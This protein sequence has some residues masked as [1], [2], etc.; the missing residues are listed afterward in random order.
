M[1]IYRI[2]QIAV[3]I[4]ILSPNVVIGQL[5]EGGIP[6]QVKKLK[7]LSLDNTDLVVMPT[8]NNQQLRK[9]FSRNEEN[10]LKPFVFA[11]TFDVSLSPGNSGEWYNTT[12]VNVWQLRIQSKSAYSLNLVLEHFKLP[13]GARLF[14]ISST[15]GE[16]KGAYT[17]A[18]NSESQI[19][20]I[21]PV[22]G[23]ELMV[24]YEEPVN[25]SFSG[26]FM[27]TKIAHDFVGIT[28]DPHRPKGPA[29][30]CNVNINCEEANGFENNRDAVCRIIIIDELCTGTL[31]NNTAGNG[32]PYLLTA[33]HCINT[34][35]KA[36][37][38]IFL[39]NY[40]SPYCCKLNSPSI[41][42]D[43]SRTLSGSSLK[44]SFDSL[45][46]ALVRLNQIPPYNYRSYLAG[47]N[48]MNTA[49]SSSVCIHHPMGD[50]KKVAVD[51]DAPLTKNYT[52]SYLINGFWNIV[53]WD[54]GVTEI[55]SSGAGLFD[56]NKR[57]IGSLTGGSADCISRKNDFFEKFALSWDYR[58]EPNKQLKA[59]LDP[60]NSNAQNHNGM[61]FYSGN[62]I[63][64]AFTNFLENDTYAIVQN[65]TG[66]KKGY[67]SGTNIAGFTE[68][69][70]QFKISSNSEVQGITFGIASVKVHSTGTTPTIDI[71]VYEGID[72]PE[73]LIQS[74]S[75]D[76]RK[77]S[78]DA[79]NYIP[80][81]NPVKTIGNFFI[82]FDISKLQPADT[83][84]VYMANRKS[85]TTNSL[86]VKN[87]IG[88]STYNS[89]NLSGN[90]SALLT[91]LIACNIN[92]P[93]VTDNPLADID[94]ARFF[95]NPVY[96]N[97]ELKVQTNDTIDRQE[98]IGVFD[99]LGKRKKIP[100]IFNDY[101]SVSLKLSG[102]Q[103]GIYLIKIQAG[104]R[105]I[106]GKVSYLP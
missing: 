44:A 43:I 4:L 92:D 73:K 68:F 88:W 105:Q 46:F 87:S 90:G 74:K 82:S 100:I 8:I 38:S 58:K 104:G 9:Q 48:R 55:G 26:N 14:L 20:A 49:P 67:W 31:V 16:I 23:D 22:S 101:N 89:Q 47:W 21:E 59:W 24:Q 77:F 32:I 65:N 62:S 29:G 106:V 86:F 66:L 95:P 60:I 75:Y 84:I 76:V 28:Y 70:E 56:Q 69:A 96:G 18:N 64:K 13:D 5:S 7:Y 40:E 1:K 61:S 94:G 33:Y 19:F 6:I 50:V 30:S 97:A 78:E 53:A 51:L 93:S 41:D 36:Q 15:T 102:M 99:L 10:S 17:S 39:F 71:K 103:A 45:D 81:D 12:E 2:Y 72:K 79:M 42:G 63:C 98:E 83:L 91:E 11:H 37:A 54:R 57:I 35:Y 85:N 52:S 80:F 27:I 25:A 3:I 34:E